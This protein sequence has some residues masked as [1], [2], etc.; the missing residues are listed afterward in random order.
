MD[1]LDMTLPRRAASVRAG[2]EALSALR[3][4][5][6]LSGYEDARL[7]VSEV[8]TNAVLHGEGD[9]MRLKVTTTPDDGHLFEIIDGGPGFVP[10]PLTSTSDGDAPSGRGLALLNRLSDGWGVFEGDSTHVWFRLPP[11]L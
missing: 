7:L 11:G 3:A 9:T 10:P 1:C 6:G 5:L 8:L 4:E 2:R